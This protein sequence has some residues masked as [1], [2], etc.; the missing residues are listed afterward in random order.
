[1]KVLQEVDPEGVMAWK[2]K[3]FK[4]RVYC[5]KVW[6][7]FIS[8]LTML[9]VLGLSLK[10]PNYVSH[11]DGYDK[12]SPYGLAIHGFIDRYIYEKWE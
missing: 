5:N 4:R 2:K 3:R 7:L 6:Y 11:M 1:M 9:I 12:L 10:G 8:I